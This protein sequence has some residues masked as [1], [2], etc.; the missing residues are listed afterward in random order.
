MQQHVKSHVLLYKA[1]QKSE[2]VESSLLAGITLFAAL[3]VA[4][5]VKSPGL[6]ALV[7]QISVAFIFFFAAVVAVLSLTPS[8]HKGEPCSQHVDRCCS[9]CFRFVCSYCGSMYLCS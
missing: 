5:L 1:C 7:S 4:L 2:L 9:C 6:L 3:P 8:Q